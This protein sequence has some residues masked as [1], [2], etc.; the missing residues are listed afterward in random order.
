[1]TALSSCSQFIGTFTVPAPSRF[2][3]MRFD[4]EVL[5]DETDDVVGETPAV[6]SSGLLPF[7]QHIVREIDC[8]RCHRV[9]RF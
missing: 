3:G 7:L 8:G 6:F 2:V 5:L 1:M 9:V 4:V